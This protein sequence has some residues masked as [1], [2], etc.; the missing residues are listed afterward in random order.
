MYPTGINISPMQAFFEHRIKQLAAGYT[1]ESM[2]PTFD[3]QTGCR[4]NEGNAHHIRSHQKSLQL[5]S[6]LIYL[7]RYPITV[8]L[9]RTRQLYHDAHLV[10]II[11]ERHGEKL[12]VYIASKHLLNYV[13][14][15]LYPLTFCNTPYMD[16]KTILDEMINLS[17]EDCDGRVNQQ[18]FNIERLQMSTSAYPNSF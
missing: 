3:V 7:I 17:I 5:L 1:H 11:D 8:I 18:V 12:G 4:C 15:A 6:V 9:Y 10:D 2:K 14:L 13:I 16:W